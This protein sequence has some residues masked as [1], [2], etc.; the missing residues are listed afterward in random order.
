MRKFIDKHL[1][2]IIIIFIFGI[3]MQGYSINKN[4]IYTKNLDREVNTRI[5]ELENKVGELERRFEL[6]NDKIK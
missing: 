2:T 5:F 6:L 3:L 1:T 4:I